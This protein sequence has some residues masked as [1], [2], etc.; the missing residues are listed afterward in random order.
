KPM[1]VPVLRTQ[2]NQN[3]TVTPSYWEFRLW[4]RNGMPVSDLRPEIGTCADDLCVVRSMTSKSSEHAQG[5]LFMH[6]GFPFIGYPS[7]G[8]WTTYGLGSESRN[9]PGYVVLKSGDAT[10]PHGGVGV[11]GSGFLPAVHQASMFTVDRPEPLPNVRP[12]EA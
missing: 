11:F 8:A 4:G 5:N 1:P 7:A 3:G 12:R 6:T 9:L 2:V 10:P